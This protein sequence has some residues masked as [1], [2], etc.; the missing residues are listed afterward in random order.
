MQH[1]HKIGPLIKGNADETLTIKILNPEHGEVSLSGT[2]QIIIKRGEITKGTVNIS[3]PEKEISLSKQNI[4]I[5]VYDKKGKLL[6]SFK[7]YFEGP[8]KLQF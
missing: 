5:G 2:N 4:E 1:F 7:T 3:F 8:F 6:D